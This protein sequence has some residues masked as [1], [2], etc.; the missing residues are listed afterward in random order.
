[1]VSDYLTLRKGHSL[2]AFDNSVL[3]RIFGLKKDE[4]KGE[5]RKS[6]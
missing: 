2:R 5:W 1:L 3:K 4:V 6:V